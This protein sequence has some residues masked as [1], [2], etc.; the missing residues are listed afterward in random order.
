MLLKCCTQYTNK[1]EKLRSG[2]RTGKGQFSFK[3]QRKAMPKNAQTTVQLGSCH[4]VARV[5]LKIFKLGFN[6][7]WT[8]NFQ[9]YN[10]DLQKAEG[11][12]IKL[13]TTVDHRKRKGIKK[14]KF[15]FCFVWQCGSLKNWKIHKETGIL[16]HLTSLLEKPVCRIRSNS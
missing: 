11:S 16:G 1:F 14:K 12:E 15:Y 10:L 7:I 2:Q 4:M 8:K 9:L 5:M 6:S 13:P 3:S